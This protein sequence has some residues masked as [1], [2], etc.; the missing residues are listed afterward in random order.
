MKEVLFFQGRPSA[1][2]TRPAGGGV[3]GGVKRKHEEIDD[4]D[5]EP[6]PND[7]VR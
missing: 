7:E 2:D 6:E 1:D 5:E 4:S 3:G